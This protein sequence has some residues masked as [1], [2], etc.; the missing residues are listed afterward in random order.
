LYG[1]IGSDCIILRDVKSENK[2]LD[3]WPTR[4]G[5]N[6]LMRVNAIAQPNSHLLNIN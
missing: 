4:R 6:N 5:Y 1:V 3:A 2:S